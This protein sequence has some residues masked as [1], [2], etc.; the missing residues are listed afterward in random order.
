MENIEKPSN[1]TDR[2][3]IAPMT[4]VKVSNDQ[5]IV[6]KEIPTPKTRGGKN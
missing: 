6:Q 2:M 4:Q 3:C 1:G 5:E